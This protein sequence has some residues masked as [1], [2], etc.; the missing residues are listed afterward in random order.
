MALLSLTMMVTYSGL[1]KLAHNLNFIRLISAREI[2][3]YDVYEIDLGTN[4]RLAHKPCC[5]GD[6]EGEL[7]GFYAIS[8]LA[9]GSSEFEI[10]NKRV[11]DEIKTS[12]DSSSQQQW[13]DNY[14]GM[15]R[16]TIVNQLFQNLPIA[17]LKQKEPCY[18]EKPSI[19]GKFDFFYSDLKATQVALLQGRNLEVCKQFL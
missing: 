7:V 3:Q 11:M 1:I 9:D 18:E 10:M 15:A 17:L 5:L 6:N 14:I 12:S 8:Q 2:Y 19:H 13:E 4:K 16:K